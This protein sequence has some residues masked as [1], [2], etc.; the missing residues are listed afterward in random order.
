MELQ[1]KDT[2]RQTHIRHQIIIVG[3]GGIGLSIARSLALRSAKDICLIER[4]GW[5]REASFAAAGM[6]APQAEADTRDDFFEL[7]CRSRDLYPNF[8]AELREETGVDIQLDQTGTLYVALDAADQVELDRRYEWQTRAGLPVERLTALQVRELE[9]CV[10]PAVT[11]A[12]HFSLDIQ[13][14]NRSLVSALANSVA[15]LGVDLLTETSV[16]SLV[17]EKGSITGVQTTRGL[18]PCSTVVVAAGTW[19]SSIVTS[20][21]V[22]QIE[23]IRGQMI[24]FEAKP[25]LCRHVIYSRR[26]YLVPRQDGRLLSG[27]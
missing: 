2:T 21:P 20:S 11:G 22:P 14:D 19:T 15:K 6:L 17:V 16:E 12:L 3:G 26:G 13:V 27:S 10:N 24:C 18:I 5:G 4:A 7:T 23:P 25:Q 1:F 9:P 8:A